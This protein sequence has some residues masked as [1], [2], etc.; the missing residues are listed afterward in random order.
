MSKEYCE[1]EDFLSDQTFL[2]WYLRS[3]PETDDTWDIWLAGEPG[4]KLLVDKAISLLDSARLRE[5]GV[6]A[7]QL[8]GAETSLMQ[9]IAALPAIAAS[10]DDPRRMGDDSRRTETIPSHRFRWWM[11][12]ACVLLILATGL[13]FWQLTKTGRE[14]STGYGQVSWQ[15]LP[16][17][18]EVMMNA[19]SR[20]R[21]SVSSGGVNDREVWL[22]GE[23]Y[24]HVRRT[25][26]KSRFVV[27]TD[28][29]DVVVTGTQ[30]NVVNRG[31]T[32][33]VMLS[34]GSVT[35]H[36]YV[37][38]DMK[39]V[40]GDFVQWD[41]RQLDKQAVKEDSLT[42]WKEHRLIFDKTPLRNVVNIIEDQY[43]VKVALADQSIADSTISGI[44]PNDNLDILL[45][46]LEL[47]SDFD[48]LR[49]N[50]RITIKSHSR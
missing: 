15:R 26:L 34:E 20:M 40:P 42:A 3:H 28:R 18:T 7:P 46:S 30:F 14:V 36:P 50:G 29:F 37:G 32:A 43:G 6:P 1:P 24:F 47:T 21:Y 38:K 13:T 25:P 31:E 8:Q 44:M 23:A 9:K 33:N 48:V 22:T 17:G 49:D 27:H 39:M 12:A 11:A 16:D 45:Q 4:R 2:D 35:L 10:V 19:N 41:R 5:A